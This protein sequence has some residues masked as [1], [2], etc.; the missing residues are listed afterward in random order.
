MKSSLGPIGGAR[1][2]VRMIRRAAMVQAYEVALMA[3][4]AARAPLHLIGGG[5]DPARDA[6]PPV[7]AHTAPTARPVLLVHGFG[8]TKSSWSLLARTLSAQGL[9]VDAITYTPFGTSVEQ[10]ADRLVAEVERL[11][12]QT[13]ADKVHLVGHSLGGVVIAQAI[14]GGRLSGRVD[15]VVTLGVTL[16]GFAVGEPAAVRG[17]CPGAAGGFA[18][19]APTR[20]RA[21]AG[22]RAVAGIHGHTRHDR[23]RPAVGAGPRPS[24]DHKGWRRR[25]PRDAHESAGCRPHSRRVAHTRVGRCVAD[26]S[27]DASGVAQ[28]RASRSIVPVP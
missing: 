27:P 8:G 2:A 10:L 21:G 25:P 20:L 11:L 9:T 4:V 26:L 1:T 17:D 6:L 23:A 5:F 14:A 22:R 28:H 12:S 18:T 24:G 15:T 3:S 19:I 7:Q 16:R 13:G